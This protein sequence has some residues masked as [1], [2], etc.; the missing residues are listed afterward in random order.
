M[1]VRR[2]TVA[3]REEWLRLR[4]ALWP[5]ATREEHVREM[6]EFLDDPDNTAVFVAER[7]DGRLGGFLEA[8]T[9]P[10]AEGC[11]SSPVGYVEGWYVD[12]DLRR[13]GVGRALIEAAEGWA[14]AQGLQEMASDALIDNEVSFRAHLALGYR[15][16]ERIICFHKDLT[17][18]TGVS[19]QPE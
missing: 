5:E 18:E 15:E 9:R 13:G 19:W 14:R 12:P 7:P 6:E 16:A 1:N 3:D 11:R 2:I 8:G 17:E 10:Y 4:L